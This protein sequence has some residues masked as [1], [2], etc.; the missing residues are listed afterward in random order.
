MNSILKLNKHIIDFQSSIIKDFAE[1]LKLILNDDVH[2]I[3][4]EQVNINNEHIKSSMKDNNKTK[5]KNKI[6]K[7]SKHSA[8][9][10]F[11]AH[12]AKDFTELTQ[13]EKWAACSPFWK[14]LKENGEY[15]YWQDLADKLNNEHSDATTDDSND[16]GGKSEHLSEPESEPEPEPEPM[17]KP[18]ATKKKA[19]EVVKSD[20]APEPEPEPEQ[21]VKKPTV[22][23]KKPKKQAGVDPEK[24]LVPD[25]Y[26]QINM[27]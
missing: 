4:D 1:N 5:N 7:P 9:K 2:S 10:L 14:E 17:K 24:E 25:Q 18:Q 16:D 3:I 21:Q 8:W 23:K 22:T 19:E 15:M 6:K 13:A 11:A 27:D 20:H 12:K 26:I